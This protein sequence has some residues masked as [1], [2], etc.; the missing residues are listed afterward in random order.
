MSAAAGHWAAVEAAQAADLAARVP[1]RIAG[2]EVGSVARAHLAALADHPAALAIGDGAVDL[3]VGPAERDAALAEIN[4]ALRALGLVR[5]WRDETY[6]IVCP[7]SGERLARTERAASRFWGTLTFG[8]HANGWVAGAGGRP[9][10]L[11]IA[12][13]SSTKATDPGLFDNLIGGGVPDGQSPRETLVREGWEEA[14]LL[15]AHLAAARPGRVIGLRRDIPEGLQHEWLHA[16]DVE[17]PPGLIPRNQD[18]EVQEFRLMPVA[19]A[20]ELAAAGEMTVDAALVTMDFAMR[21]RLL[22]D[23]VRDALAA[24]S[25]GLWREVAWP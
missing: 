25:R 15:P 6:A 8:A 16:F 1:F 19:E 23:T 7:T 11:W 3:T 10:H 2:R 22:P 4:A 13:R 14:G 21:Q 5:A 18:G 12:R 17:L 24:R 20:L 9:S